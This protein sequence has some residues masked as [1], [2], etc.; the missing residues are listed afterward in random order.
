MGR[1]DR[2]RLGLGMRILTYAVTPFVV[3]YLS[4]RAFVRL[5]GRLL[6]VAGSALRDGLGSLGRAV[7]LLIERAAAVVRAGLHWLAL[8]FRWAGS[9]AID[10]GWRV[11]VLVVALG[12][13]SVDGLGLATEVLDPIF[14]R[15]VAVASVVIRQVAS[16]IRAVARLAADVGAR[17]VIVLKAIAH[18]VARPIRATM[19]IVGDVGA[20]AIVILKAIAHELASAIR[21]VARALG[22]TG[23]RVGVILGAIADAVV[24]SSRSVLRAT[25]SVVA[26]IGRA[27]RPRI[28][29]IGRFIVESARVVGLAVTVVGYAVVLTSRRILRATVVV[30]R[31]LKAWIGHRVTPIIRAVARAVHMAAMA[32]IGA[33]RRAATNLRASIRQAR[34]AVRSSMSRAAYGVRAAVASAR[35]TIRRAF[36]AGHGPTGPSR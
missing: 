20:R 17:V 6:G 29:V 10:L 23:R 34:S 16:A 33:T 8:P 35:D 12:G 18:A 14:D 30:G 24:E 25:R 26:M 27:L 1:D 22:A 21:A 15:W 19:R 11:V 7:D 31:G 9:L 28:L 3:A 36:P 2:P 13:F 5:A 32:A 4:V